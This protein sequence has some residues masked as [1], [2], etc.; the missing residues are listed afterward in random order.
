MKQNPIT[1]TEWL[2]NNRCFGFQI[3]S[4]VSYKKFCWL[5]PRRKARSWNNQL[6]NWS[7]YRE[8]QN[9]PIFKPHTS[10][11][12]MEHI[13]HWCIYIYIVYMLFSWCAVTVCFSTCTIEYTSTRYTSSLRCLPDSI[14]NDIMT[15]LLSR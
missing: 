8:T 12:I 2:K 15:L 1:S 11:H 4:R 9:W 14:W 6:R 13:I 10:V 5:F 3:K 7:R